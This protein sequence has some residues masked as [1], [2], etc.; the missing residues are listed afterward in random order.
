[1]S[2]E[3]VVLASLTDPSW[4]VIE[5]GPGGHGTPW[6]G[7]YLSVDHTAPGSLGTAG[8]EAGVVCTATHQGDMAALPVGD[9]EFD[10]LIGRHILEHHP[11]TLL[12]LR[13]WRRVLKPGGR[14]VVIVPDQAHYPNST[15]HLDPTHR[16]CF[17]PAQL[18]AL[19]RHAGFV[20][21]DVAEAQPNWSFLLVAT[22]G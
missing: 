7:P 18:S 10:A 6:G 15:I 17:T 19:A 21:V 20:D 8:S 22:R 1:M 12:V 3:S 4:S 16:A 14:L 9:K 11:D 13:E 5:V 2:E